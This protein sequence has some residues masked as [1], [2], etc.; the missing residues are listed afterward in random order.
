MKFSEGMNRMASEVLSEK[1]GT[2]FTTTGEGKLLD[3]FATI[4]GL[5]HQDIDETVAKWARAY[6]ENPTLAANL[7]L[8]TRD[9]REGGIGERNIARA[10]YNTLAKL[11]PI[12]VATNFSTIVERGRWD[13]L[14]YSLVGTSIENQMWDFVMKQLVQDVTDMKEGKPIS[15]LAK[16]LPSVNTSSKTTREMASRF[17]TYAKIKPRTYR[18]TLS[19]LREYLNIVER[20]MSSKDWNSIEF[21]KVPSKAMS[22]YI[23]AFQRNATER[24]E[25]YKEKL[26]KGET[27]VNV[28][29]LTPMDIAK[30]FFNN[31]HIDVIDEEQWKGLPNYVDEE[32]QV[33]CVADVSGSMTSSNYEPISASVGLATYFAQRNTGAYHNLYM[34]F[35]NRPHF[36]KIEDNWS[37]EKCF[38]YVQSKDIGYST[39]ADLMFKAIFE[40]AKQTHEAPAGVVVISDGEFDSYT[41]WNSMDSIVS[42]WN[43]EYEKIGLPAPRIISWNVACRN[44]TVIAPAEDGIAYCS[45]YSAGVF[46]NLVSYLTKEP[47]EAM[48]EVLTQPQ[49]CWK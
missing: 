28:A 8:Y 4:G 40:L 31:R 47:Y 21:E 22:R 38:K 15:L 11:E 43:R 19:M 41:R 9:I 1:M 37:I 12:K 20:F 24:F 3:L 10:L 26:T 18:K 2:V 16:W 23:K 13:D 45:G 7:I 27:K 30:K 36:L 14:W 33:V 35:T 29:A 17:I 46:K 25:E 49:F 34:T 5:R 6:H 44:S 42:K 39:N 32:H 48:V